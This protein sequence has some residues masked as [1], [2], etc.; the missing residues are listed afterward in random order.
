MAV[1]KLSLSTDNNNINWGVTGEERIVQNVRNILRTRPLE[2]PFMRDLGL[3]WSFTDSMPEKIKSELAAR[4]T[5]VINT[6]EPRATVLS[7]DIEACDENGD[8]VIAVELEV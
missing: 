3:D 8:Y 7:V 6:Y 1:Y 4:V 5:E 2:I